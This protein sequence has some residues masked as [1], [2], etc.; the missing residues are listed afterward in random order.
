MC[1][2]IGSF[3]PSEMS[4]LTENLPSASISEDIFNK[5][6]KSDH[7][8]NDKNKKDSKDRKDRKDNKQDKGKGKGKHKG[9]KR[10]RARDILK[11]Q[12]AENAVQ[13]P[14]G[15]DFASSFALVHYSDI[16]Q[17][18]L[19]GETIAFTDATLI[20][21]GKDISYDVPKFN[22]RSPGRYLVSF[23]IPY[24]TIIDTLPYSVGTVT[25]KTPAQVMFE[26]EGIN[27]DQPITFAGIYG[28]IED[29][30]DGLY[31]LFGAVS[32]SYVIEVTRFNQEFALSFMPGG[33]DHLVLNPSK[34]GIG[35]NGTSYLYVLKQD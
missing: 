27:S 6:V 1:F 2:L 16:N 17:T 4:A 25:G 11:D 10:E 15:K 23:Y 9:S 29:A 32:G 31:K 12:P 13:G 7:S 30:N 5:E 24:Y 18:I 22:F 34:D 26:L 33:P 21:G 14:P 3:A 19:A 35:K 8:R 20:S 28:G